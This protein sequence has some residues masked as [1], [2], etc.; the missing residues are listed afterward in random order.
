QIALAIDDARNFHESQRAESRLRLLLDLTNRVVRTLDLHEL[1]REITAS[2]RRVMDCDGAGVTLPDPET[3][4]RRLYARDFPTSK[5]FL[6]GGL[7]PTDISPSVIKVFQSG[8]PVNMDREAILADGRIALE[9]AHSLCR[10]PLISHDRV[11]G[12]LSLGGVREHA[13]SDDDMAFLG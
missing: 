6:L 5:G 1:L 12:V 9:G 4:G 13:F 8:Q 11:L 10:L 7:L 2:L 3:G